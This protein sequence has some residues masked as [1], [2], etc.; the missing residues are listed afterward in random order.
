MNEKV[1]MAEDFKSLF[2]KFKDNL[3]SLKIF[4]QNVAP[5]VSKIDKDFMEKLDNFLN[6]VKKDKVG[7]QDKNKKYEINLSKEEAKEIMDLFVKRPFLSEPQILLLNKSSFVMLISYFD[8]LISDIIRYF[9]K[10]FSLSLNNKDLY[11]TLSDLKVCEN[12]E[13]ALKIVINKEVE[14]I[15]YD[16]LK[17]Q[18]KYFKDVLCVD[19]QSDTVDW[20]KINEA[21]ERRNIIVHNDSVINKRYL[22]SIDDEIIQ[23]KKDDYEIG[24]KIRLKSSYFQ[25]IYDELYL[26]AFII[27]HLCW[28]KWEKENIEEQDSF[29]IS[30]TYEAL[31]N[32]KW[33]LAERI[34][35][36][37]KNIKNIINDLNRSML[38]VNYLQALKW[39]NKKDIFDEELKKIDFSAKGPIF[40]LVYCALIDDEETFFKNIEKAINSESMEK[41]YFFEWP[42]FK[43]FRKNPKY[44]DIVEN[45]YSRCS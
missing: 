26:A 32:E 14:K 33:F 34:G 10:K 44:L 29:L 36:F 12:I 28:R 35:C 38:N 22:E 21:V 4:V 20:I 15:L 30:E 13:E 3:I 23:N 1:I 19:V 43:E 31:K 27:H 25:D 8:F 18:L 39:Q 45:A 9:Y 37:S 40:Q 16:S 7:D 41:N 42:I 5:I 2:F 11:I 17:K 6:K 24:K